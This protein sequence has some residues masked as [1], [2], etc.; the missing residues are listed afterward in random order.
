MVRR[1]FADESGAAMVEFAL[2]APLLII[3]M[4]ASTIFTWAFI[5]Y[6]TMTFAAGT[7]AQVITTE[8]L[9]AIQRPGRPIPTLLTPSRMSSSTLTSATLDH[10]RIRQ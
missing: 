10:S 3:L 8:R 2:V 5:N 4:F 1:I 6:A 7:G 9:N